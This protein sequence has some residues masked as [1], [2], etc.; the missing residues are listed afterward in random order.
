MSPHFD[1]NIPNERN[2]S[3]EEPEAI[4]IYMRFPQKK[5]MKVTKKMID[6]DHAIIQDLIINEE[7]VFP[8]IPLKEE[9]VDDFSVFEDIVDRHEYSKTGHLAPSSYVGDN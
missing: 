1:T 2:G 7:R 9:E 5:K 6:Q 3:E 8:S 4:Y